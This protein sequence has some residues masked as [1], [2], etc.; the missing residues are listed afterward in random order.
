MRIELRAVMTLELL[1][2]FLHWFGATALGLYGL[3]YVFLTPRALPTI[4][5]KV[6]FIGS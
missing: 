3:F 4:D 1:V 5:A 6:A 2:P